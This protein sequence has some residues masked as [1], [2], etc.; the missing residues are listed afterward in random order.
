M[1][2]VGSSSTSST[3]LGIEVPRGAVVRGESIVEGLGSRIGF[4]L[5]AEVKDD[6]AVGRSTDGSSG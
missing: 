6:A 5:A 4:G 2:T 3:S 1:F